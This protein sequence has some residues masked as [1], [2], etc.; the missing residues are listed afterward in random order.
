MKEDHDELSQIGITLANHFACVYY[1]D[2]ETGSYREYVYTKAMSRRGLPVSGED[3]FADFRIYASKWLH[4]DDLEYVLRAHDKKDILE[5]LSRDRTVSLVYRMIIH[6][7]IDHGRLV[8]VMCEDKTHIICCFENIE[9]E[10][11]AKKE[12]EQD[13]QSARLMARL[14]KL[15]GIRNK[16]A[17]MEYTASIDEKLKS[18]MN[19]EP[20]A[21]VMCDVNDL[22]LI[23]DTRGHSFGDEA[24]RRAS[25]MVCD[26]FEHSP[27]FRVGGDEFAVVLQG[28]DYEQR[29]HLFRRLKEES[30]AN[31][32]S[33]SG[34]VVAC[35]MADYD[36]DRD[37]CVDDVFER[38]DK[39]MYVI[40]K[41]MKSAHLIDGLANMD[42]IEKP[43]PDERRRLLDGLFGALYTVAGEGY[44]YLND[45][46]YDFSRWSLS[47]VDDFSLESEYMVHADR[48][49]QNYIHPDDLQVY[50]KAVDTAICGNA[51]VTPIYYR[52]RKTDGTYV[53]LTTRAF[54]LSDSEGKPE[55]FGG[56][57]VAH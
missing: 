43:I 46:R 15:T 51:Q 21:F 55:Y 39:Q 22:K 40:K 26:V 36:P 11:R 31:G 6:G 25:C 9:D 24:I 19:R 27:V 2:I 14:D 53:M 38:A 56:I 57:M 42:R 41:E 37:T 16:N 5:K 8:Y 47:L 18:G 33:R 17:Y 7:C 49:W 35:G 52:A 50:R 45:M 44:V 1:V 30:L 28:R 13:L 29:E 10:V 32:R 4:P 48:I 3:Y 12:Q 34:P 23:N 20:F 54:I